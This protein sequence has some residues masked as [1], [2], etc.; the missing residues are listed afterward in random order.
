MRVQLSQ[1]CSIDGDIFWDPLLTPSP[2]KRL[3]KM[4]LMD[5]L[6]IYMVHT[7]M[8]YRA[9]AASMLTEEIWQIAEG[10]AEVSANL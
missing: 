9:S 3:S 8:E 1:D 5:I 6:T 4:G 2:R 7:E 10:F